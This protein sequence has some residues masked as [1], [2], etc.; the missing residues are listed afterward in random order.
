M[1]LYSFKSGFTA[2]GRQLTF[3]LLFACLELLLT[4]AT[5]IAQVRSPSDSDANI[6]SAAPRLEQFDETQTTERSIEPP[7][8][9]LTEVP[10][11]EG[12]T[13]HT[14]VILELII[15]RRGNVKTADLVSGSSLAA[16][17]ALQ[18]SEHWLFKPATKNGKPVTSKI[19]FLITFAP[20][21]LPS[22]H[23]ESSTPANRTF[24]PSTP[25]ALPTTK[26]ISEV[27]VQGELL[28][29]SARTITRAE[30][31]N[32]AGAFGDPLRAVEVLPG[33]TPI[34]S[35]LPLFFIR[36]APPGNVGTFID[37]IK[38]PLLYHAFLGPSVLHPAFIE[39]VS[40][41]AGPIPTRYGRFAG[42]AIEAKLS[43]PTDQVRA[44][45]SV[46]LLDA[47]A[48]VEAPIQNGRGYV[49]AGGRY[50]YT[51][52]I[53]SLLQPEQSI[54]Y[55]DYQLLSGYHLTSKDEVSV[56]TFGAFDYVGDSDG[57]IG[58][59][60]FHRIDL[61]Y[62]HEFMSGTKGRVAFTW[63]SD[64][65]RSSEGVVSD[66]SLGARAS[67]RHDTSS[68]IY[69]AGLDVSIDRYGLAVD[70]TI[71]EPE[72]YDELFPARTDSSGGSYFDVI[73]LPRG[74]LQITPGIRA[75]IYSSLGD[76]RVSID[77][78]LKLKLRL[79]DKL[80]AIHEV[81]VAHQTP[82]FVPAIPGAQVAGLE[83]G[84]QRSLQLASTFKAQLPLAFTGSIT[85]FIN[86]T[87]RLSDPVG[88]SQSLAIDETSRDERTLGRSFGVEIFVK[89]S[90]TRR[91]GG[92]VSYT[93]SRTYRSSESIN[94]P[95]GYER[96]H[97][98]N[99][100]GTYDFGQHWRLS[101]KLALASGI[102][103]RRTTAQ[104]VIFDESRSFPYFRLDAKLSKRWYLSPRFNWGLHAEILN[105]TH[106]A[107]VSGRICNKDG[108]VNQGTAP[109]TIPSI[110]ID[111][112]WQ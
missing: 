86:G 64:A 24:L 53:L 7:Y 56:F 74:P 61:R 10:P 95:P 36:G 42:A 103:G 71:Q 50:S 31:R 37:G 38:V 67:L 40:L 102:L 44:E 110:G 28:D 26:A 41:H 79:S 1:N 106:A 91:I 94:T 43:E 98:L 99:A 48:F 51:A 70:P 29:P 54:E 16:A 14:E 33:V 17:A 3:L 109:I 80:T 75:D 69:R 82:N 32:L 52:L 15:D 30:T 18:A 90:L 6:S 21:L 11:L 19:Q 62:A 100:A 104:G 89:R 77:P 85:G 27:I 39:S 68:A 92:L 81:A 59:T 73:L 58:G 84:L 97:V 111:A 107:Q 2:Q 112:A 57:A 23:P 47:G 72:I 83:G 65:T 22:P 78:R 13:Q 35:G 60:Q 55:W 63:G 76:V 12:L 88:T 108:C 101:T 66:R 96:P 93:Y 9:I 46:R 4:S 25:T 87:Q 5:T 45:A 20:S 105:M 34:A 8:A 49:L